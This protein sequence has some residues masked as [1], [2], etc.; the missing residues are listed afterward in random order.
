[1]TLSPGTIVSD[2]YRI[3]EQLGEGGMGAVFRAEHVHM[4]KMVALKVLLSD[5]AK[6][7]EVVA[8]FERE[9]IAAGS[10]EHPNVVTA[11]DFGRLPDG[12]FFLVMEYVAGRSLRAELA[13]GPLDPLRALRVARGILGA[14]EAAHAKNIVHRDLKPENVMLVQR[15]GDPDFVKVL[16]FG[17]AKLDT[18]AASATEDKPGLT[19]TGAVMGTPEYMAPEQA[20]GQAVDGRS[21][22][23]SLGVI[24]HELVTGKPPFHGAAIVVMRQ[25]VLEAPPPLPPA[26]LDAMP[27]LGPL[28]E[29]LLQKEPQNRHANARELREAFS[30]LDGA[31]VSSPRLPVASRI[32]IEVGVAPSPTA[33]TVNPVSSVNTGAALPVPARSRKKAMIAGG[34]ALGLVGLLAIVGAASSTGGA[35]AAPKHSASAHATAAPAA[36]ASAAASA[37]ASAKPVASADEADDG[38]DGEADAPATTASAAGTAPRPKPGTASSPRR[39]STKQQPARKTGPGGIYIPPP[40]KWFD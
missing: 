18:F 17:I 24:L 28:L 13:K 25:Q 12:A 9:A 21:D 23:Y 29:K 14:I 35:K 15:D 3:V 5:L 4:K 10:I 31:P 36:S 6:H 30:T 32:S 22:L 27:G 2:R 34:A 8:R 40:S 7:P 37:A 33:N 19:R 39:R 38:D 1:V 20:L 11:T 16:D 26:V